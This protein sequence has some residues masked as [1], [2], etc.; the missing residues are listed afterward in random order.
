MSKLG[1]VYVVYSSEPIMAFGTHDEAEEF[2][3][4]FSKS[5]PNTSK[6]WRIE[7]VGLPWNYD[8]VRMPTTEELKVEGVF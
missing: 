6:S 8:L 7:R 4:R 2:I 5:L 1:H 3:G